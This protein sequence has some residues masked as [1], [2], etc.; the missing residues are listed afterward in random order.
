MGGGGGKERRARFKASTTTVSRAGSFVDMSRRNLAFESRPGFELLPLPRRA[1]ER[2]SFR[3]GK[4]ERV[5]SSSLPSLLP[6]L[7][8]FVLARLHPSIDQSTNTD[9]TITFFGLAAIVSPSRIWIQA[10][11]LVGFAVEKD[12][13]QLKNPKGRRL[14]FHDAQSPAV[15]S[16]DCTDLQLVWISL[17]RSRGDWI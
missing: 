2:L 7:P 4:E 6:S 11:R 9:T 1:Q 14:S 5:I 3:G 12:E 8:S 15:S 10:H 16:N 17:E 13:L